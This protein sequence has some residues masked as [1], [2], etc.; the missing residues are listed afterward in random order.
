MTRSEAEAIR[1]AVKAGELIARLGGITTERVQ[2]DKIGSDWINYYVNNILVKQE[3]VEQEVPRGTVDNPIVYEEGMT[4]INN[5]FYIKDG[6]VYVWM[7]EWV[8]WE[9]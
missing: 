3:Y 6:A 1:E 2:S 5:A 7:G 4:P 9:S 8:E